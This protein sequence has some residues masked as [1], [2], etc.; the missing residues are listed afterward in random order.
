MGLPFA[1]ARQPKARLLLI[2]TIMMSQRT[3]ARASTLLMLALGSANAT[4]Q[5]PARPHP[6]HGVLKQARLL[7]ELGPD[8]GVTTAVGRVFLRP[9][10]PQNGRPRVI[11][12]GVMLGKLS[13]GKDML[14]DGQIVL[15]PRMKFDVTEQM[16]RHDVSQVLTSDAFAH[17]EAQSQFFSADSKQPD[18]GAAA[19]IGMGRLLFRG[20]MKSGEQ[21]R[22]LI[23][24]LLEADP[25]L[26]QRD[27]IWNVEFAFLPTSYIPLAQ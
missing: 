2:S 23:V 11:V 27:E 13:Q 25:T 12:T 14:Q 17:P 6:Q 15:I 19:V 20:A 16:A 3:I 4:A 21:E 9:I 26:K 8:Y 1:S 7:L 5:K 22:T 10:A 24:G 18:K